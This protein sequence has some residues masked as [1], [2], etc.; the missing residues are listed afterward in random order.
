[1]SYGLTHWKVTMLAPYTRKI[2]HTDH[3]RIEDGLQAQY[4]FSQYDMVIFIMPDHSKNL[5]AQG[6]R[7][8]VKNGFGGLGIRPYAYLPASWLDGQGNTLAERL[9]TV[10]PSSGMAHEALHVYGNYTLNDYP[11][12]ADLHGAVLHGYD[13]HDLGF[14]PQWLDWQQKYIRSQVA[15]DKTTVMG[16]TTTRKI[17]APSTFVG[18]F[19]VL[20]AGL[21]VQ[22]L[23]SYTKPISRIKNRGSPA[24][25]EAADTN[26]IAATSCNSSSSQRW[27]LKHVQNGAYHLVSEATQTCAEFSQGQLRHKP[28][29]D[30]LAQRFLI[31]GAS[32]AG[33]SIRTLSGE[34]LALSPLSGGGIV[35]EACNANQTTQLWSFD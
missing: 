27:S 4:D 26:R 14:A 11:G 18:L 20:H 23:W 30:L 6:N 16:I 21:G 17:A 8:W 1:M 13:A 19:N 5:D 22:Q 32:S 33:S 31:K 28:C 12:V 24:C 15:E 35:G 9:N 34:C 25:L 2:Y 3:L 10:A 7:I 29:S